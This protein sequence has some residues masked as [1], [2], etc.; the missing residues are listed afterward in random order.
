M[1]EAA[2]LDP[3]EKYATEI[4][5]TYLR[6]VAE[7]GGIRAAARALS[8]DHSAVSRALKRLN[9]EAASQ[10]YAPNHWTSGAAPGY[11]IGKVTVHRDGE[12]NVLQT[13]E[14]EH[15]DDVLGRLQAVVAAMS[16][17]IPRVSPII[18]PVARLRGDLLNLY[19]ITDAHVG[20]LAWHREGGADWDLK[21]AERQLFQ[22]FEAM[23]MGSPAAEVGFINQLGDFLHTDG[24]VP[25]TPTSHNILD[26]DGRFEKMVTVA[27]RLLRKMVDLALTKHNRVVVLLAEGNHDLASSVWLRQLFKALYENEPRVEVIQSALPYYAYQHGKTMLA[28]HHGHLT[29]PDSLTGKIAAGFP[30]MWG[31]TEYRYAHMGHQHHLYSKDHDGL[32]VTQHPTLA[33]RDAYAARGGWFAPREATSVTYS[34]VF[35]QAGTVTINAEMFE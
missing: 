12:G 15:P 27:I 18:P 2:A 22:A 7:H 20:M 23:V 32:R 26:A 30:A 3:I 19:T 33:A 16:E 1:T 21:I 35:G 24:M 6:A 25:M 13:W 5:K 9:E 28:F 8:V 11:R 10:G 34:S 14:R 29:K 31:A 17:E 4:Q